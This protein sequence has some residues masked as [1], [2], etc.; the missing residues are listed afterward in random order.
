MPVN[1]AERPMKMGLSSMIRERWIAVSRCAGS[2]NC[3]S[4]G[5]S[6][7]A[8]TQRTAENPISE[9]T[10]AF[11]T[12]DATRQASSSRSFAR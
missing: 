10:I 6:D 9:R 12:L 3:A 11:M 2:G 7:G 8:S 1:S 5:T 4:V